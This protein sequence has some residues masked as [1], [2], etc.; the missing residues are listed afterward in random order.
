M[1]R[2]IDGNQRGYGHM[3]L[4]ARTIYDG[5]GM[6]VLR[7]ECPSSGWRLCPWLDRFPPTS[8]EF[9]WNKDS[10]IMLA[11]GHKAVSADANAIIV[12]ALRTEP[13]QA[14]RATLINAIE[15]L[16]QFAS[17]D[18]LEPWPNQVDTRIEADF[19][20]REAAAY[21]AARQQHGALAVPFAMPHCLAAL[22][23]IAAAI[24]LLPLAWRRRHVAAWFLAASLAVL[25]VSAA[26]TGG[27]S[28]PHDRYQSRVVWLPAMIA[29][30]TVPALRRRAP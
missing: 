16:S 23:G 26:I 19:P 27:L 6:A 3:F 17:G 4:L 7:A 18:G 25:P 29:F 14:V 20:D 28:T 8:D 21:K 24:G 9:M 10:P 13:G 2:G 12:A 1:A 30:L 5:P 11:G 22:A 15:Q